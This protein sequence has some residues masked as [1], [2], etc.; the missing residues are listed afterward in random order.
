MKPWCVS[1]FLRLVC[2]F[3]RTCCIRKTSTT[4]WGIVG[5][6][7][8]G[9][10]VVNLLIT[11]GIE[12]LIFMDF[13]RLSQQADTFWTLFHL[14]RTLWTAEIV[15]WSVMFLG[16][17]VAGLQ[18]NTLPKW[19][20]GLGLFSA[21]NGLLSGVPV[22]NDN[23]PGIFMLLASLTGLLWFVSVSIHMLRRSS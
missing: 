22:L 5:L 4:G 12:T 13:D 18:S 17:S 8:T 16:F 9:M 20:V 1:F 10:M 7:G 15:A 6:I 21:A 19:I 2:L 23:W 11:N 14:T 3:V